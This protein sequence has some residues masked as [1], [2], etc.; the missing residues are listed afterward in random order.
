MF[1]I[2]GLIVILLLVYIRPQEFWPALAR[3]PWMYL[4]L[5]LAGLGWAIDVRRGFARL[6]S[7]PILPWAAAYF[8][9]SIATLVLKA[10]W[11]LVRETVVS[12]VSF[13][14]FLMMAGS[15]Q[16]LR[17]LRVVAAVIMALALGVATVGVHQA[18]AP[19]GCVKEGNDPSSDQLIPDGRSCETRQDCYESNEEAGI[20]YRCEHLGLAGT[21]S[22]LG[23]VRYRGIMQDPNELAVIVSIGVPFAIAL[24]ELRR[25]FTRLALVAFA[26][27]IA[28]LCTIFTQ[29][30][31]GQLAYMAMLGVYFLRRWRWWGLLAA[32]IVAAPVSLL[33]GRSGD[34]ADESTMTRYEAWSEALEMARS[35]PVWGV[36][37]A[38]FTEYHHLTAHN[39]IMLALAELGV[40]GLFLWSAVVYSAFKV[41]VALLRPAAQAPPQVRLWATALLAS[42]SGLLVSAMFLSFSDHNVFW[43]YLGLVGAL[44]AGARE[45]MPGFGLRFSWR[46]GAFVAVADAA[47]VTFIHL[48]V[49][50][51]V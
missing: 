49:R 44:Y 37:K 20:E 10:P 30:R 41:T 3:V 28:G 34:T 5:L 23:R 1:A 11:D 8:A 12:G 15:L 40:V 32:S 38:Q 27:V 21:T 47:L 51:K 45:L 24:L 18:H 43:I 22:V 13:C 4:G 36:G 6:Q 29:S 17:A 48:Y 19:L 50:T 33:G 16:T 42:L 14:F 7:N 9:W 35:S 39:S 31:S 2:P 26:T 25:S 46:D